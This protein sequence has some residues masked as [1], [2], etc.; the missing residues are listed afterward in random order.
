MGL[1]LY[2]VCTLFAWVKYSSTQCTCNM[3]YSTRVAYLTLSTL[4]ARRTG[5]GELGG[6]SPLVTLLEAGGPVLAGSLSAG[7]VGKGAGGTHKAW[8]T[9]ALIGV[10][11]INAFSAIG[12][13]V[14]GALVDVSLTGLAGVAWQALALEGVDTVFAGAVVEAGL[15]ETLVYVVFAVLAAPA[16]G[17]RAAVRAKD[18]GTG[19]SVLTRGAEAFVLIHRTGRARPALGAGAREPS[20]QL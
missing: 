16:G 10:D 9:S 20:R 3:Q 15:S 14:V 19:S 1:V 18:V 17:A 12:A 2:W 11:H 6:F 4:E 8:R 13:G 5:A 7:V